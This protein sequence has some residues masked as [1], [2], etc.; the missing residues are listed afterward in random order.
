[1]RVL[2]AKSAGFCRGV[3]RAVEQAR[4][5]ASTG[6]LPVRTDG[7]LIHNAAMM[8]ALSK[9]GIEE[10]SNPEN[11]TGG[12]LLIRAHGIS[13]ERRER[14]RS[15]PVK[16][17]D[18]T[19]PDVARIQGTIRKYARQGHAIIVFGDIGHAEVLGLLG[20]AEKGGWVVSSPEEVASLPLLDP[21]CLVAQS[22]QLPASYEAV[23]AAVRARFPQVV[24]LDTI[25]ESTRSRQEE[26][27][28]LASEAEAIV[29]VGDPNSA[30]TR[31]LAE[32]ARSLRPTFQVQSAAELDPSTIR[33]FKT[34]A[35]TAG[36]STPDFV[37][38]AVRS[39]LEGM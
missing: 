13:P 35:L 17:V 10:T 6:P 1:M 31:R 4:H 38:N 2:L 39:A 8:Q 34:V 9:E 32:L 15:L 7:R 11:L 29:V 16:L 28:A 21:V 33:G 37:L 12:T 20:F 22:T 18:A 14:L 26:L 30:N 23:A 27:V 19:C 3:R 5:L 25:C 24:V 36:A